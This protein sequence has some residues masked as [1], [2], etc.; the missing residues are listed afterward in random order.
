MAH[1]VGS[2]GQVVIARE[3]GERL[4]IR[5]GWLAIETLVGGHAELHSLPPEHSRSL[6]GALAKHVRA[7]APSSEDLHHVREAA[8][9]RRRATG[10][11]SSSLCVWSA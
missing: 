2:K 4:G 8:W 5:P 6:C 10:P 1:K 3:I 11:E 7:S 9:N